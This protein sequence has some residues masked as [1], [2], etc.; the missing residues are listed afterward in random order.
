[1]TYSAVNFVGEILKDQRNGTIRKLIS[2]NDDYMVFE[3][4]KS[5]LSFMMV[6]SGKIVNK[7]G[8]LTIDNSSVAPKKDWDKMLEAQRDHEAAR[9]EYRRRYSQSESEIKSSMSDIEG[10]CDS[11]S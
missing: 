6:G 10:I 4:P 5:D 3:V 11:L 7:Y 1:M 9:E 8:Q 2:V